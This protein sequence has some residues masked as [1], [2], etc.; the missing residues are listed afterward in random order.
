MST[1]SRGLNVL[2]AINNRRLLGAAATRR[3]VPTARQAER[4]PALSDKIKAE[5]S[6]I[7][8]CLLVDFEQPSKAEEL[9]IDQWDSVEALQVKIL[10]E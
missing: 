3:T 1:H 8:R 7:V 5:L 6:V 4:D 9:L 2:P 10:N